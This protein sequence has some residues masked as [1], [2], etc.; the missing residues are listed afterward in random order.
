MSKQD[1]EEQLNS[2][3]LKFFRNIEKQTRGD[4]IQT[5]RNMLNKYLH[6]TQTD[7]VM[8]EKDFNKIISSAKNNFSQNNLKIY[9]GERKVP[10]IQGDLPNLCVIEST[11]GHLNH[12]GCLKKLPKFDKREDKL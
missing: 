10:V 6:I 12:I 2:D 4:Q 8:D 3:I 9:L 5:L 7:Y 1:I 11:I